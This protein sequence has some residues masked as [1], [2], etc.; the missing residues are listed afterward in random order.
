MIDQLIHKIKIKQAE[1][2]KS[3]SA[4]NLTSFDSYQR[5]VGTYQGLQSA[6]DMIDQILDEE[7]NSD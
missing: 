1:I 2:E 7:K 3:M 6:L 4:G 5:V